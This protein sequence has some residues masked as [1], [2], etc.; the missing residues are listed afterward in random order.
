MEDYKDN[1]PDVK[2]EIELIKT[3]G[4]ATVAVTVNTMKMKEADAREWATT[5]E[6]ELGITTILPLED[7][8][9]K[10]VPIFKKMIEDTRR[11]I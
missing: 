9:E 5:K 1:I 10:L 7:G 2:D 3:Y 11:K 6:K 8:V 4:A